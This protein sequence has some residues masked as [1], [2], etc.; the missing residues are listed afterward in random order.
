MSWSLITGLP[1]VNKIRA[2]L[3]GNESNYL[4]TGGNC[5]SFTVT[6]G[7]NI[8]VKIFDLWVEIFCHIKVWD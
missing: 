3:L 1:G 2:R 6:M 8:G 5:V 7:T 4:F